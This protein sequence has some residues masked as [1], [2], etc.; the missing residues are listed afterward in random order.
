VRDPDHLTYFKE[1]VGGLIFGGYETNPRAY[2]ASPIPDDHAFKLMPENIEQFEVLMRGALHRFPA[3]ES[4]GIKRWFHGI[5]SFT[6]DGMFILGEAP[7]VAGVF[8]GCGFNSF[9][10]AAAGGAGQVLAEWILDGE[11]PY[12][13]WSADIR[14]FGGHSRA[15]SQVRARA[16]E[17]QAH[18]YLIAWPGEESLAGRPLRRGTLHAR[19]AAAG[20]CYGTK[21]GWERPNWFAP[22]GVEP[23]DRYS[24]ERPNWFAHVAAEHRACRQAAALFDQSF[25]SKFSLIG[26]DAERVLQTICAGDV[27][28]APGRVVYTQMLNRRG[29]IEADLT[30]TRIALDEYFIV[31]GTAFA[32]HDGAHMRRHI[33]ADADAHLIDV[34]SGYG[35]LVL[36]GPNARAIL[37]AV[38]E[39]DVSNAAFPFG[40]WRPLTI[41][42][43]PARALRLTFVGELG[44]ELHIPTEYMLT[45]YDA[46]K[47]AGASHGLRDA[48][49]RAI[50]SLRL[51]KGY[52]VW[53]GDIGPDYTPFEAGLGFA[54][55][56][57]KN[58][59]FI[60]RDALVEQKRRGLTRRLATFTVEDPDV[61]LLGRETILRDGQVVGW[62]A[63][64]G[65]G[66]W[67]KTE[68]GLG[69]VR[70]AEGLD[71]AWL[72]SGRYE[73]EVRTRRV[74]A[75]LH[76][77]PLYDPKGTKMVCSIRTEPSL[78]SCQL[79]VSTVA[80]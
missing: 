2:D 72:T 45:A 71:D 11:A 63:S 48:G 17:G 62:I 35:T 30:V 15:D 47:E 10:I 41:A 44:W 73:L 79:V 1:E 50:D 55:A 3:L 22:A 28:R 19:L 46:L 29:G 53:A 78:R 14:R 36:M 58:V 64:A 51:E 39:E 32:N 75:T 7:E 60:G 65:H 33:P 77:R 23:V 5:E 24:F 68:I 6:E 40:T 67:V 21:A 74:P 70:R 49:Y 80:A 34:T 38:A 56:L 57:D 66:H 16:L 26:R 61:V 27:G 12:D 54:V 31:T 52:R 25:F 4:T 18:H 76:L 13:L 69:Y 37:S 9:G 20:A 59:D 43:A 8:V 42:G